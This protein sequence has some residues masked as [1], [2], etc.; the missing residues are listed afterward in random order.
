MDIYEKIIALAKRR[1]F[2]YP[3]Y[4][5][6]GGEA[7]FY[8]YGPIGSLL[9]NNI[10]NKWRQIYLMGEKFFEVATPVITPY[11][12]LKASG[13]VDKFIDKIAT[14]KKCKASFKIEEI[15]N[16]KC[17]ICGGEVEEEEINLMFETSI[18]AKKQEQ[19]FLRPETAQG[20]F[21]NFPF[22]H[23]FFRKKIPFGI[24][25][26]GK[27][28][29][30]EVS[31]RQGILRLREFSMAEAEVF[32]DPK[33][34][35][36]PSFE[37]VKDKKINLLPAEGKE[38]EISIG[39]AVEKNIIGNEAL[40]YYMAITNEFL[41]DVGV[42]RE[43]IRFRQHSKDELAHYAN[44]CWDAEIFLSRFGWV[45]CVG[46]ADRAAHDLEAHMKATGIDMRIIDKTKKVKKVKIK[47]KMD[48]I[49]KVFKERA[50]KIKEALEN[51]KI[52]K[53]RVIVEIDGEEIE[54]SN[55]FFEIEEGED[56]RRYI[57][58]VIE[59]SYG[60]DR[61]LYSILE[62]NYREIKKEG[63]N[64]ILLSLPSSIAP[65]KAGVFPLVARD[66]LPDIAR[67]IEEQLRKNGIMALY[68]EK[69]SIGRRYARMDE[70][71][72]PFCITIDYQTKEDN[73]ITIRFRDTT[74]QI[75]LNK[76]DAVDWIKERIK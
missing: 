56:Y 48:K 18:G 26:I 15:K 28:F 49:G 19:A 53:D 6:Y 66:G 72:T 34:K 52:I 43:K 3:S 9:K 57:P 33:H 69:G 36:H 11:K 14:C 21:V 30:N 38:V 61:I 65:I 45:E 16:G 68:D 42:S 59:P 71:G 25:Q 20:I 76:K 62:H 75:R 44:E 73:T 51:I 23:E 29:R 24:V 12:V 55:E 70:I 17:P 31:P 13:H 58:H 10:E 54:I 37:S 41:L 74:E 50:K 47:V 22:L 63:E 4:S 32:F 40:A 67:E 46:I 7:G 1:G 8:D 35:S 64:Y 39:E 2:I 60:I 27:G 5:I